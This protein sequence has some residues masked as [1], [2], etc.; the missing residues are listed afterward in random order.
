MLHSICPGKGL[1]HFPVSTVSRLS[2]QLPLGRERQQ[3]KRAAGNG[4][5]LIYSFRPIEAKRFRAIVAVGREDHCYGHHDIR[6]SC[7]APLEHRSRLYSFRPAGRRVYSVG[8]FDDQP[9][10]LRSWTFAEDHPRE[11][12]SERDSRVLASR[13]IVR[14][15]GGGP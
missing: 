1:R 8:S 11:P 3:N 4:K 9:M 12:R 13:R 14:V 7:S 2:L 6:L 5:P 15:P 10:T